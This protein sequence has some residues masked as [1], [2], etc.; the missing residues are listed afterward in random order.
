MAVTAPASVSA[1]HDAV[2]AIHVVNAA[3]TPAQSAS[4]TTL[5]V[6]WQPARAAPSAAAA[7]TAAIGSR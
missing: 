7:E 3:S 4:P 5:P 6:G 1:H 2:A